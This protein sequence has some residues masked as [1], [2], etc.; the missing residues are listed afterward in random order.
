MYFNLIGNEWDAEIENVTFNIKMPKPFNEE[1]LGF[2]SGY[3]GSTNNANVEYDIEGKTITGFL[4][5]ILYPEEGLTVRLTLPDGYFV[6]A[7]DNIDYKEWIGIGISV[8]FVIIA[9][10][11]W[12]K[13]GKDDDVVDTVEFYPPEGLNSAELGY[14]YKGYT[15]RKDAVSL[16][17]YLA[18]KGYLSIKELPGK[19]IDLIGSRGFVIEKVKDYDGDNESEKIF[20][21][22]LFDGRNKV[23]KRGVS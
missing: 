4:N 9:F 20:F 8:I 1:N 3:E 11:L 19:E 22:G 2:S 21:N 12:R 23:G 13:Y 7:T 5:N 15:E 14:M 18:N 16:L 17:I 10:C 6:G